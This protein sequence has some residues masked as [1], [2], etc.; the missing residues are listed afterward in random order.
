MK[1]TLQLTIF[2]LC[3]VFVNVSCNKEKTKSELI[4]GKWECVI[5][6]LHN[7]PEGVEHHI[8]GRWEFDDKTVSIR[9]GYNEYMGENPYLYDE[10]NEILIIGN[11]DGLSFYVTKLTTNIMVLDENTLDYHFEFVRFE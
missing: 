4:I 5:A 1:K 10:K 9:D 7:N 6:T 2:L 11:N 8:G 3:I